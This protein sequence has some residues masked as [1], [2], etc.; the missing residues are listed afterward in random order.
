MKIDIFGKLYTG[1]MSVYFIISGMNALLDID[2]KLARIG[3]NAVDQDGKVRVAAGAT[4]SDGDL[5]GMDYYVEGVVSKLP[6]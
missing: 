4:M 6:N 2:T 5:G 3:L 1:I